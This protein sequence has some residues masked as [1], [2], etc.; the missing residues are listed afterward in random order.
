MNGG[1]VAEALVDMTGGVSQKITLTEPHVKELA[2]NGK[3]WADIKRY[4]VMLSC[5]Q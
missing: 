2:I 5:F 4:N 3:L 1:S